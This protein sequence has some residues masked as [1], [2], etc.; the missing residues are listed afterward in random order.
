ME[1]QTY[2][3]PRLQP[4]EEPDETPGDFFEECA[5]EL[6]C[7]RQLIRC[8]LW[9]EPEEEIAGWVDRI[10]EALGCGEECEE[11]D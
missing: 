2:R 3:D 10:A 1:I 8:G 7:R 5:H 9:H 4:T 6:A 11:Y